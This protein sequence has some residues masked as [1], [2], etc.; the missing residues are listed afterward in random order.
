MSA[1]L[2]PRGHPARL[3]RRWREGHL[4][5]VTSEPLLDELTRVLAR[6]RLQRVRLFTTAETHLYVLMIQAGA[7][8]VAPTGKLRLCRDV[9]DDVVL[10]TALLG[11][12]KYLV[13]RDADLIRDLALIRIFRERGIQI[14]TVEQILQLMRRKP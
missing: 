5:V 2:N 4:R 13:S 9:T 8:V 10:E 6:P 1:F 14:V 7:S 11:R 3:I 12:A